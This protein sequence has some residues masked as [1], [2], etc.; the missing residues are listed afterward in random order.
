MIGKSIICENCSDQPANN[1]IV[2]RRSG[3]ISRTFVCPECVDERIK[4]YSGTSLDIKTIVSRM[5]KHPDEDYTSSYTCKHCGTTL[6]SIVVDGKPG[7]CFC[8]Y[9]FAGEIEQAVRTAQDA[10]FHLGKAPVH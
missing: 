9:R 5:E 3:D 4:L 6:A 1:V 10:E 8:Y 7:C 2:R